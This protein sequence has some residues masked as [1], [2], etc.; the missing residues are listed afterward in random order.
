MICFPDVNVW[1]ALSVAEHVHHKAATDWYASGDWDALV[2]SRVTQMGFLR[3]LTNE[4]VMGKQVASAEAAWKIMDRLLRNPDIH[5]E[6]EPIGVEN[7]W[8]EFTELPQ[9]GPN[10]WTDAW[11][12][13]FA[14]T[15]GLTLVTFDRGFSRYGQI[16]HQ[17]LSA[18]P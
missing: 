18:T 3:L 6:P 15:T 12:A 9:S 16:R 10:L 14:L 17:I 8:R 2:F 13:A 5:F 4:H 1:I 7:V 11:L